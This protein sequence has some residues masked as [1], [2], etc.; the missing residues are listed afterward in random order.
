M[1]IIAKRVFLQTIYCTVGQCSVQ[2]T[3]N[4]KLFKGT[5]SRDFVFMYMQSLYTVKKTLMYYRE[6]GQNELCRCTKDNKNKIIQRYS[7]QSLKSRDTVPNR[8]SCNLCG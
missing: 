5:V 4:I 8:K 2:S 7:V 3:I 6:N 1:N